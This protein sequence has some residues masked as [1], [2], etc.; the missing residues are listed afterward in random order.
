MKKEY[1]VL[2]ED[3]VIHYVDVADESLKVRKFSGRVPVHDTLFVS[4]QVDELLSLISDNDNMR[5][6]NILDLECLD[7]QIRQ[8]WCNERVKGKWTVP[9]LFHAYLDIEEKSW[10]EEKYEEVLRHLATCYIKM[11][12]K[13]QSEWNRI[14]QIELPI[15]KILYECQ[16]RGVFFN[17]DEIEPRCAALYRKKIGYKNK[18]QLELG[19]TGSDLEGYLEYKNISHGE[20]NR[21]EENRLCK[22]HPELELF[23]KLQRVQQNFSCLMFL[24]ANQKKDN[25]CKPLFKGFGSSTGRITLRD[26]ALQNLQRKNRTLLK[27]RQLPDH[28]RYIYVDYGQFEAGILAG[29]SGTPQLQMLYKDNKV[30]EELSK[31]TGLDRDAAKKCFYCFV[32]G[33]VIWNGAEKFFSKYGLQQSLNS[34]IEKA[35]HDGYI[36]T[37]LG[38]RRLISASDENGWVLNHYIQGTSSLIF[39]QA[40]IDVYSRFGSKVQLVLPMHDAALYI[41]DKDVDTKSLISVFEQAFTKWIPE[42]NPVVKEK[43]F[44]EETE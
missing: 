14:T 16:T 32:Y 4:F 9:Q 2:I 26:P 6:T 7:T 18:I 5:F 15:N 12:E 44:F 21:H 8:S 20:L 28:Q 19:Y 24:A 10:E 36:E 25:Y 1:V 23:Q 30:Y 31:E 42:L 39:K 34:I 37:R 11:K 35:R 40:L 33:G 13:G 38:N 29:L 17:H 43:D 41:V 3:S 27:N 22:E